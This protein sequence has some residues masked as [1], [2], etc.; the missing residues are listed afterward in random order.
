MRESVL[1]NTFRLLEEIG[2][3]GFG[4][5]RELCELLLQARGEWDTAVESYVISRSITNIP[6]PAAVAS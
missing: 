4:A 2:R 3:G 5:V 6:A 1:D